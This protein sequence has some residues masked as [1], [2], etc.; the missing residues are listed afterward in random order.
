LDGV[1]KGVKGGFLPFNAGPRNCLGREVA[2]AEVGVFLCRLVQRLKVRAST[3]KGLR[4]RLDEEAVHP[5]CRVP[6]SW[7]SPSPSSSHAH[8]SSHSSSSSSSSSTSTST[9]TSTTPSPSS[10][11]APFHYTGWRDS[12]DQ[13]DQ[14]RHQHPTSHASRASLPLHSSPTQIAFAGSTPGSLLPATTPTGES[15]RKRI[16]RVWPKSHLTMFVEGGVWI[17]T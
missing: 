14:H 4:L 5:D 1:G 3:G 16:E 11:T 8:S 15:P 9:S 10:S 6:K 12:D 2:Y 17:R 13:H 7:S